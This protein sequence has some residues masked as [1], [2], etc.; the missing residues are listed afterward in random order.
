MPNSSRPFVAFVA[1]CSPPPIHLVK[2]WRTTNLLTK[3]SSAP[4]YRQ[5]HN[6]V[7]Q[8]LNREP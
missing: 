3:N 7:D 2:N 6:R 4:K 5:N 8:L 1:F